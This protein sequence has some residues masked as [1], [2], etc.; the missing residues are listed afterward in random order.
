MT[1]AKAIRDRH[2]GSTPPP[3][4]AVRLNIV[5]LDVPFDDDLVLAHI[6]SS[7]GALI[8]EEGH[9]DDPDLLVTMDWELARSI[10][11]DQDLH[12]IGS[13]WVAQRI[14]IEGDITKLF[15]LQGLLGPSMPGEIR[16]TALQVAEELRAITAR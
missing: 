3:P 13:A 14:Q 5:V 11:V 4:I 2:V 9:L 1:A 8:I 15:A 7:T 12:A 6:D 16:S 10:L